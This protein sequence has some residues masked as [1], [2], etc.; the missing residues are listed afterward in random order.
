MR[1]HPQPEQ[2][3]AQEFT[4]VPFI[5]SSTG[6]SFILCDPVAQLDHEMQELVE[7][8]KIAKVHLYGFFMN[9]LLELY[10]PSYPMRSVE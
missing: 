9:L 1:V 6:T 8:F 10:A 5:P 3:G 2:S 7:R 4:T